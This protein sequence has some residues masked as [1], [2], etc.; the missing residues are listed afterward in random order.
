MDWERVSFCTRLRRIDRRGL[1]KYL[2]DRSI[3]AGWQ[4]LAG[5]L[6]GSQCIQVDFS[7][8]DDATGRRTT[9]NEEVHAHI[10]ELRQVPDVFNIR[11]TPTGFLLRHRLARD[12]HLRSQLRLRQPSP[13]PT[14]LDPLVKHHV[15]F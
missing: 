6:M 10:K 3:P 9:S 4:G 13:L 15:L 1:R 11:R 8:E 14:F 12:P 5:L 2:E 7:G